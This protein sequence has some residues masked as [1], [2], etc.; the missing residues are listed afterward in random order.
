MSAVRTI[1]RISKPF[2]LIFSALYAV[3]DALA[4]YAKGSPGLEMEFAVAGSGA[5]GSTGHDEHSSV[6]S[7]IAGDLI[8]LTGM[9]F[10]TAMLFTSAEFLHRGAFGW[11]VASLAIVPAIA[12][13]IIGRR[14]QNRLQTAG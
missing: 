9:L 7:M 8:G 3:V 12:A 2:Y 5:T 10:C 1:R 13:M 6:L 11:S 14:I 4:W